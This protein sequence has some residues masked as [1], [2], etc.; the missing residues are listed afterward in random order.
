MLAPRLA[1]SEKRQRVFG[2]CQVALDSVAVTS[3]QGLC[4]K[5]STGVNFLPLSFSLAT[6]GV[7]VIVFFSRSH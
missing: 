5:P 2:S 3:F 1:P 6:I 7:E 4:G